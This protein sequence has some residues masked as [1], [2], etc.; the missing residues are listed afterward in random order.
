MLFTVKTRR[1]ADIKEEADIIGSLVESGRT[2]TTMN[3]ERK[4]KNGATVRCRRFRKKRATI[5]G[6]R[7]SPGSTMVLCFVLFASEL[8]YNLDYPGI[9]SII[10]PEK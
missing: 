3:M 4:R 6:G 2:R 8:L 10:N 5:W 1:F 9:P 7:A